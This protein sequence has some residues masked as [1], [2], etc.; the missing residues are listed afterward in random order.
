MAE[1]GCWGAMVLA[2]GGGWLTAKTLEVLEKIVSNAIEVCEN[3]RFQIF[4]HFISI[5]IPVKVRISKLKLTSNLE[6]VEIRIKIK[7]K[8]FSIL[9]PK[10]LNSK[11]QSSMSHGIYFCALHYFWY[12]SENYAIY[13][14]PNTLSLLPSSLDGSIPSIHLSVEFVLLRTLDPL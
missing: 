10:I 4:W 11:N 8:W 5:L 7:T 14:S 9:I 2:V 6:N 3:S 1:S 12:F 13:V